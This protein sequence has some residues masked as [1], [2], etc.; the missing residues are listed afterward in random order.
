MRKR[1]TL[2]ALFL[3]S[4]ALGPILSSCEKKPPQPAVYSNQQDCI[5]GGN[6]ASVCAQAFAAARTSADTPHYTDKARCEAE[7]GTG[8]CET[9]TLNGGGFS[10]ML[11][12]F[13]LG[14][15]LN[16][17]GGTTV[18]HHYTPV[19][20]H[21]GGGYYAG[22]RPMPSYSGTSVGTGRSSTYSSP[23]YS[24]STSRGGFGASAASHGGGGGGE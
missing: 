15:M 6:Q 24:G 12:G 23:S 21:V 10:P 11:T 2:V 19:Y 3:A 17:G 5:N 14:S 7:F 8:R 13:M 18:V 4:A 9:N 22:S 16:G 20:T 1:S